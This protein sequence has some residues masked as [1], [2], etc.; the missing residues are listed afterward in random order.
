M[1]EY[2]GNGSVFSAS[3]FAMYVYDKIII[4]N[5][6]FMGSMINKIIGHFIIPIHFDWNVQVSKIL[7]L[8]ICLQSI[9]N[10][11]TKWIMLESKEEAPFLP[12]KLKVLVCNQELLHLF[13][14]LL[15]LI[16]KKVFFLIVPLRCFSF[17]K[18][19]HY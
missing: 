11:L 2:L 4:T 19:V 8:R 3:L 5:W 14:T 15:S 6:M 10:Y 17:D 16:A 12:L 7:N 1:Q 9:L 18:H 13:T